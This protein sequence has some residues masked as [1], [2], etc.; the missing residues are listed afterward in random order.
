[1]AQLLHPHVFN[2]I[3]SMRFS[4]LV[5]PSV[6]LMQVASAQNEAAAPA[7][8]QAT[9]IT[10]PVTPASSTP[11]VN[12]GSTDSQATSTSTLTRIVDYKSMFETATVEE[13]VK[14][15]TER[16]SLST[17]QQDLWLRAATDRRRA[18]KQA[19]DKL[20]SKSQDYQKNS[21]YGGLRTAQNLFHES[22][23]GHLSPS[24]KSMLE[25][26]RLIQAEKQQI[27]ANTPPPPPT[28]SVA[29]VQVDSAAIKETEKS[30]TAGKKGKK[31]KKTV[32]Q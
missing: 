18:E 20:D 2:F 6:I 30:K 25:R 26:D 4:F 22:I 23:I 28:P 32:S 3:I 15:A 10:T 31:K 14:M 5:I 17:D 8:G 9:M 12:S 21:V 19:Y 27:I 24:Q 11:V 7:T 29:P 13:E 1:M 16:L